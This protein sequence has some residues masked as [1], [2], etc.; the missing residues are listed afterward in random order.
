M[1]TIVHIPAKTVIPGIPAVL[2]GQGVPPWVKPEERISQMARDALSLCREKS[3]P[4]GL[5][6]GV[7]REE[8][9]AVLEGEGG[10][11]VDVPV[12][13]IY[14]ASG[15]LVLFAVTLGEF[16]SR[17]ISRRFQQNDFAFA[18]ML[19]AAASECTEMAAQALEESCR[20]NLAASGR[21]G[22][23]QGILRF[24]PGY[25]GWHIS[26]QKKLFSMLQPGEIGITLNESF[27]MQPI[28]SIT[29]V[30]VSGRKSIFEFEDLFSFC[31][32]CA[33][34]TCRER[35]RAMSEHQ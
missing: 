33:T 27:L 26:G 32:D 13:P 18:S 28:K 9:G 5:L 11:A 15:D 20:R 19:D 17:E 10:N 12:G 35:I 29:G 6:L 1:H 4:V 7:T 8:F 3:A 30:I 34:H 24:S 25:C 23:D 22:R 31:R 21:S 16:I 2:R 14:R